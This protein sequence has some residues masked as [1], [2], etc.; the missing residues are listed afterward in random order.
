[1]N[2]PWGPSQQVEV[3]ADG[4]TAVSTAGHGGYKLAPYR[5]ARVK[6]LFPNQQTYAPDGWLEEDCDWALAA[7]AWPELFSD[8]DV[9]YAVQT[10][11]A[12]GDYYAPTRAWLQTLEGAPLLERAA[13]YV[14]EQRAA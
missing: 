4:I 13:R 8:R 1:M 9:Y 2:T 5:W 7:L 11:K 10:F 3:I 6:A 12:D 14:P